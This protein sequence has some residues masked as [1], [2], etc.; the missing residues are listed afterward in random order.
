L[1]IFWW[2][3]DQWSHHH[4]LFVFSLCVFCNGQLTSHHQH[5]SHNNNHNN[6]I[7]NQKMYLTNWLWLFFALSF[8]FLLRRRARR[9]AVTKVAVDAED[10]KIHNE[11]DAD[12]AEDD[13]DDDDDDVG[14][15]LE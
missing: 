13:Y 15:A 4:H 5:H 1:L 3:Y 12:D 9:S 10:Y 14:K 7:E 8:A 2:N 11:D 6:H